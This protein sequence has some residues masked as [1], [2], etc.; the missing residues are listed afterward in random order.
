MHNEAAIIRANRET[1][2]LG[3]WD[4]GLQ[5]FLHTKF[6]LPYL[7]KKIP[8]MRIL[9][10]KPVKIDGEKNWDPH[11]HTDI[12]KIDKVK[13]NLANGMNGKEFDEGSKIDYGGNRMFDD[14]V[15]SFYSDKCR[16]AVTFRKMPPRQ[17]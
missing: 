7:K 10:V 8:E 2:E 3:Q 17:I 1:Q 5:W 4:Y 12:Y 15:A 13:L 6:C 9:R 14:A 16:I 11:T